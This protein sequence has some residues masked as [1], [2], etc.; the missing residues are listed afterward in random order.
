MGIK[1]FEEELAKCEVV[2]VD[3]MVFIY[4]LE[5]NSKYFQL[6][7]SALD[8]IESGKVSGVTSAITIAE[9]LTSPAQ[10]LDTQAM[11][12]YELFLSNFPNLTLH[13]VD[14]SMARQ[15]ATIRASTRLKLPDAIQIA[16]AI[17]AGADMIVS[18][19]KRWRNKFSTPKL[20]LLKDYLSEPEETE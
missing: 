7:K 2:F 15:I 18:N 13:P 20:L 10:L 6:A 4:L 17:H 14:E 8:A 19:D 9:I 3:T 5:Q 11:L 12:D 1:T 16:T